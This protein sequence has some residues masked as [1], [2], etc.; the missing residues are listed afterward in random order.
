VFLP[1]RENKNENEK[2]SGD[3]RNQKRQKFRP[4]VY[5]FM[6][7]LSAKTAEMGYKPPD[8][9]LPISHR[10]R[11]KVVQEKSRPGKIERKMKQTK[12][13]NIRANIV[14]VRSKHFAGTSQTLDRNKIET[15]NTRKEDDSAILPKR[16]QK[17]KRKAKRQRQTVWISSA[18][19]K[20]LYLRHNS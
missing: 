12:N 19:N 6:M 7:C 20:T 13:D 15:E 17:R 2:G 1:K 10:R 8:R 18:I 5:T 14:V 11:N 4:G 16:T 3:E 9:A